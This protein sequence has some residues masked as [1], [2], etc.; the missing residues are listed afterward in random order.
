M[1]YLEMSRPETQ[2]HRIGQ[3]VEQT[4]LQSKRGRAWLRA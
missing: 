1:I 4:V 3:S 2:G